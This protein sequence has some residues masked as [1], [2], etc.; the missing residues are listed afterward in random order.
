MLD[1]IVLG[2]GLIPR[3]NGI[4]PRKVPF[5]ADKA[6]IKTILLT[7]G[8][9][10][11]YRNPNNGKFVQ[12]TM[13][14]YEKVYASFGNGVKPVNTIIPNPKSAVESAIKKTSE[15]PDIAE[16][17]EPVVVVE[18]KKEEAPL[19]PVNNPNNN[20]NQNRNNNDKYNSNKHKN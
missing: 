11:Y 6:L 20:D 14:N 16:K 10:P 1:I 8:L 18:E 15:K 12:L 4:A 3:G 13:K 2:V 19:V 7:N 17:K 5:K 9:D